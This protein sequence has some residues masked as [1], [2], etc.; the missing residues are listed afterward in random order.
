MEGFANAPRLVL[1]TPESPPSW[2]S[3]IY[4]FHCTG[5]YQ[6]IQGEWVNFFSYREPGQ[7]YGG[8]KYNIKVRT[9][10]G[11]REEVLEGPWSSRA[12]VINK[13]FV[14]HCVDVT[15][16]APDHLYA[17]AVT[18]G[19]ARRAIGMVQGACLCKQVDPHDGDIIY[20][21]AKLYAERDVVE[22]IP[23]EKQLPQRRR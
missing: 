3:Y 19:A 17:A 12:G 5:L 21:P 20:I 23:G 4:D 9:Q 11:F 7:G 16:Q 15:I 6:G 13:Y 10:N 1:Y 8:R 22:L 14:T 2:D 18:L